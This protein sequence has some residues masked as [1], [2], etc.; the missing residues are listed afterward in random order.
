MPCGGIPF[1]GEVAAAVVTGVGGGVGAAGTSV[2]VPSD[3]IGVGSPE[4]FVAGG[5]LETGDGDRFGGGATAG[6]AGRT[7]P[8]AAGAE[9][10]EPTAR[11][12]GGRV[13]SGIGVTTGA[14]VGGTIDRV[15]TAAGGEIVLPMP[16]KRQIATPRIKTSGTQIIA[17]FAGVPPRD[18]GAGFWLSQPIFESVGGG[19]LGNRATGTRGPSSCATT[20]SG[21][22]SRTS[23]FAPLG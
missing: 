10:A 23:L 13:G 3:G 16:A 5:F 15:A 2:F 22:R 21:A 1:P 6:A 9:A 4:I 20:G 18:A 19:V 12:P 8:V 11:S 17:I 14:D 7:A